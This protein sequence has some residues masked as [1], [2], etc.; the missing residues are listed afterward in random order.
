[1]ARD[2]GVR[3]RRIAACN[4]WMPAQQIKQLIAIEVVRALVPREPLLQPG[5]NGFSTTCGLMVKIARLPS[6]NRSAQH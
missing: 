2:A 6:A 1:M 4:G 3:R 5:H